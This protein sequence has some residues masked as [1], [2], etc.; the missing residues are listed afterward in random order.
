M[1][2]HRQMSPQ[3]AAL[4]PEAKQSRG[5]GTVQPAPKPLDITV[6]R[7]PEA[8]APVTGRAANASPRHPGESDSMLVYVL[9][10]KRIPLMP[11]APAKARVLLK[12]GKAKVLR[13]EPFTI[14]LLFGSSGYRQEVV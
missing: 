1:H 3:S 8:V 4:Q 6:E 5:I 12:E 13:R 10:K 9:N 14:L 7:K 2:R 11:C